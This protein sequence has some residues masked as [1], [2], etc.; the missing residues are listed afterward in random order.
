MNLKSIGI[1]S[2]GL[3]TSSDK[4]SLLIAT[5]GLIDAGVIAG[6]LLEIP[7]VAIPDDA[8]HNVNILDVVQ[9]LSITDAQKTALCA[10]VRQELNIV[11]ADGT[12]NVNDTMPSSVLCNVA[13]FNRAVVNNDPNGQVIEVDIPR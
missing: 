4:K 3:L 10:L 8:L 5:R 6:I 12:I 11:D 9:F 2:D 1:L 13:E 7:L